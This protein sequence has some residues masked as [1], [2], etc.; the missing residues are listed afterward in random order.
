MMR[1]G[2]DFTY[3]GRRYHA[4]DRFNLKSVPEHL[5]GSLTRLYELEPWKVKASPP[6]KKDKD[7]EL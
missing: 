1:A 3:D 5:H 2:T 7:Y 6:L 4:G